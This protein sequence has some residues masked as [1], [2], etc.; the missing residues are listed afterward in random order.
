[1]KYYV[2]HVPGRLRVKIPQI[3]HKPKMTARIRHILNHP[4]VDSIRIKNTTGSVLVIYDPDMVNPND[5]L[6]SLTENGLFDRRLSISI[7]EQLQKAAQKTVQKAGK[8]L[9]GW[10]VGKALEAS[11]LG[12]LA[13]LI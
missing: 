1:M 4:G 13:A 11:G 2:H 7:D 10:T 5:L 8:L 12:L 3:Q 6:D 9:F